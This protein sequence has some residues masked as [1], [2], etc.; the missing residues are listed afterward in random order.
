MDSQLHIARSQPSSATVKTQAAGFTTLLGKPVAEH[1]RAFTE[2]R[3]LDVIPL[4]VYGNLLPGK[5]LAG[6][7]APH[8]LSAAPASV[9]GTLHWHQAHRFPLL[10]PGTGG[11]V[12]GLCVLVS[13]DPALW[14]TLAIEELTFG[15]E[16]KWLEA[17]DLAGIPIGRV[18]AF[19]WPWEGESVGPK[20]PSGAFVP[21]DQLQ[22]GTG[23]AG[24][25]AL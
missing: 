19:T 13:P 7:L 3:G 9:D 23:Y 22:A 24:V 18:L 8:A 14:A 25:P 4:F 21:V 10:L 17:H 2:G 5:P 11:T 20:L 1:P 15:Y 16:G 6:V 12:Y